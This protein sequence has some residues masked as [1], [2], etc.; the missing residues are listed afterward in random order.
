MSGWNL[1]SIKDRCR[2]DGDC[3]L[4]AQGANQRSGQPKATIDGKC[5]QLV[6]RHAVRLSGLELRGGYRV[7]DTCGQGLCCNPDH[8]KQVTPGAVLRKS[9]RDGARSTQAE[10]QGRLRM[11]S[12]RGMCKITMETARDIRRRLLDGATVVG[13]AQEFGLWPS[14]VRSIKHGRSWR[15]ESTSSVFAWRGQINFSRREETT[16]LREQAKRA[17]QSIFDGVPC[18][19]GHGTQRYTSDDSCTVCRK[20]MYAKR[21]QYLEVAEEVAA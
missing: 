1:K 18:K 3:W 12:E 2:E 19:Y 17:G 11:A 5:G 6:R 4:W 7:V 20:A 16:D 9:Y 10:Y 13:L 8:L 14:S 15:E 21:R